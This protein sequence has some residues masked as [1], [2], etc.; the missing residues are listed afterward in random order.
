MIEVKN[1]VACYEKKQVLN[2]ISFKIEKGQNLSIVGRN[3]CGKSTL[4]KV[5]S[6]NLNFKGEVNIDGKSLKNFK[7]K[8]LAK[9]I[10]LLSQSTQI[11]FNYTVFDI[12]MMGRYAHQ[13]SSFFSTIT[14]EDKEV[15]LSALKTVDI[16]DLKDRKVDTLSGGQLQ[17]VFLA[18]VIAQD[19]EILLLDEPTNNLDLFYQIDFVNFLKKW[20]KEKNKTIIGVIH[21]IN[22]AM[23]LS[24]NSLIMDN[25]EVKIIGKNEIVFTSEEFLNIYKMD[26][27]NFMIKSLE[28]WKMINKNIKEIF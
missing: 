27:V 4:L 18:K 17:R 7:G 20:G 2:G 1:I 9:K 28:N 13:S 11:Y 25:G 15:V 6:G 21:D 3:G 14:N 12:V 26:T 22:L 10:G 23:E 16:I 5:L 19:P 24:R 8:Q